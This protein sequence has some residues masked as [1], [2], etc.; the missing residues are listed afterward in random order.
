MSQLH[1]SYIYSD[2]YF[3]GK[4]LID[5]IDILQLE[6]EQL[7]RDKRLTTSFAYDLKQMILG[8][9]R[10]SHKPKNKEITNIK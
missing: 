10:D 5:M 3:Y 6:R 8:L 4:D 2:S 9:P 7:R 1:Y